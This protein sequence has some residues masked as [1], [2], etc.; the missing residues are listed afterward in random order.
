M[1]QQRFHDKM[2]K[3]KIACIQ[4]LKSRRRWSVRLG[5][6]PS[7][8]MIPYLGTANQYRMVGSAAAA[9]TTDDTFVAPPVETST[10]AMKNIIDSE[11][12]D[13]FLLRTE[14]PIRVKDDSNN[15]SISQQEFCRGMYMTMFMDGLH[16]TIF[17]T[18]QNPSSQCL[19]YF[20]NSWKLENPSKFRGVMLFSFLLALLLEGVAAARSV[21]VRYFSTSDINNTHKR[22]QYFS[23]KSNGLRKH[24]ILTIVYGL[25]AILGYLLMF[26]V[27]SFSIELIVSLIFGLVVGNALFVRYS[28]DHDYR[29]H[30]LSSSTA[31]GQ[32]TL[33]QGNETIHSIFPAN[34]NTGTI[35]RRG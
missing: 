30:S 35:R 1:S 15:K 2:T 31:A 11:D 19:N 29:Y 34:F 25:Q 14:T 7:V 18:R 33:G 16:W 28:N 8:M 22:Q 27:M 9:H 32:L 12:T 6:L 3:E 20:V 17:F 4:K 24:F 23:L 10:L 26:V 13:N 21:C 5:F